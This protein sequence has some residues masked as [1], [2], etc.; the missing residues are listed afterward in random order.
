M[1]IGDV[2]IDPPAV[3]APMAGVTSLAARMLAMRA[4]AGAVFTEMVSSEALTREPER[5][6]GR[7][8][9]SPMEHPVAVQLFGADPARL[10][11]AAQM[12]EAAGADIVDLNLGCPMAPVLNAGAGTKLAARPPQ[13]GAC[14]RAMVAAVKV[15]V[16]VKM[17]AGA[18][19]WDDSYIALARRLVDEGAQAVTL[20]GRTAAQAYHG[21]ADWDTIANLVRAVDVPVIGNGD[22]QTGE[23]G[24]RRMN[25]TG[26][27]AVMFGRGAMGNPWV[28]QEFAAAIRGEPR[29]PEPSE[30]ERLA[31]ALWHA[32]MLVLWRGEHDGVVETRRQILPYLKGL[33][34]SKSRRVQLSQATSLKEIADAL[35]T[36]S[37]SRVAQV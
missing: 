19:T 8:V 26:C 13:A 36:R 33:A 6:V 2:T 12:A 17:R 24:L 23:E 34:G 22:L 29:P 28:F 9:L 16:T 30:D 10:A 1:K 3:Q 31:L 37:H 15:P 21:R 18:R 11:A 5:E 27:A 20:H 25:E 7:L 35:L 4:G 14:V 32:Q